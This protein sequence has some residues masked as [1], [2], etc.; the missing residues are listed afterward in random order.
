M[1]RLCS[2]CTVSV[3]VSI[4]LL[5]TY[6][7]CQSHHC[8]S[9]EVNAALSRLPLLLQHQSATHKSRSISNMVSDGGVLSNGDLLTS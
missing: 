6:P 4:I 5:P 8:R 3:K 9:H 1:A 2:C 7:L